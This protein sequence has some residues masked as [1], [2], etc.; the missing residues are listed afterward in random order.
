VAREE[1]D[2]FYRNKTK[3]EIAFLRKKELHVSKSEGT[4]GNYICWTFKFT[5]KYIDLGVP[6]K[7]HLLNVL[8]HVLSRT[9]SAFERRLRCRTRSEFQSSTSTWTTSP[10][11]TSSRR[12]RG[13]S[14]TRWT[15]CRTRSFGQ[16]QRQLLF[17]AILEIQT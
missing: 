14:D 3:A 2:E 9:L 6:Y 7:T 15:S 12:C 4:A 11:I 5:A 1:A 17:Y 10:S 13:P 16:F 8:A